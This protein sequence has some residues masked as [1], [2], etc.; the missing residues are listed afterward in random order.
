MSNFW[1][2]DVPRWCPAS[3]KIIR[4]ELKMPKC[5][6]WFVLWFALVKF[7]LAIHQNK[8]YFLRK[9]R[10]FFNSVQITVKEV[11]R[12]YRSMIR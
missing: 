7:F 9:W 5:G 10:E 8:E 1:L 6:T 3:I 11:F 12:R 4:R 2:K